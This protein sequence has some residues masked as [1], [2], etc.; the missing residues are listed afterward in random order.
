MLRQ[1]LRWT[2]KYRPMNTDLCFYS[3]ICC[4]VIRS[5]TLLFCSKS[6]SYQVRNQERGGKPPLPFFENK[7]KC[8][9][10]GKKGP[11]FVHPEV[12]FFIQNNFIRVS[13]TKSSK[14]FYCG[15]FFLD[16]LRKCLLKYPNF[17]KPPLS[18]KFLVVPL[19]ISN[20]IFVHWNCID[21]VDRNTTSMIPEKV[22]W[23]R[24]PA[25]INTVYNKLP[26]IN[27]LFLKILNQTQIFAIDFLAEYQI[28]KFFQLC[29]IR[30]QLVKTN[31]STFPLTF[32]I[33]LC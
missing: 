24:F 33:L 30:I 16:F 29:Y 17:K 11:N 22:T 21:S 8:P 27:N 25:R 10:F 1:Q 23:V 15:A 5:T 26:P 9:S 20:L 2:S 14:I 18:E 7:E 4:F 12:K 19:H 28:K 32:C 31:S 3:C 6:L 13:R